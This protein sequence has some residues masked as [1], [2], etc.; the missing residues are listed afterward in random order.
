MKKRTS[1]EISR[2]R[3]KRAVEKTPLASGIPVHCHFDE[4]ADA[5]TLKLWSEQPGT[6]NPQLHPAAQLDVYEKVV[7]GDGKKPGNGFRRAAIVS[8]LSGCVTRGNG[9]VQM[10]RRRGWSIPIEYQDYK[11]RRDEIRDVLADNELARLAQTDKDALRQLIGELDP[12]EIQFTAV[13][14]ADLA[15]LLEDLGEDAAQFPITAKLNEEYDYV[16]I[17]TTNATE[18]AFLQNL[19]GVEPERSYK[20]TGVGIGR[21]I[22]LERA[23]AALRA[24]RHSLDVQGAD[25][26]HTSPAAKRESVRPRKPAARV[27]KRRRK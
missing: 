5:A 23:I 12:G 7:A 18:H 14:E 22:P 11:S 17:F 16:L 19:L 20:K 9:L 21:A 24:N 27:S 8:K 13:S 1:H 2:R 4:I 6:K 10:A 26:D 3:P 15:K 25:H